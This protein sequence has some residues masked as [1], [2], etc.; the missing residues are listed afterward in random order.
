MRRL[1]PHKPTPMSY[2]HMGALWMDES[3]MHTDAIVVLKSMLCLTVQSLCAA[4]SLLKHW[5]ALS[6]LSLSH[7]LFPIN[8]HSKT[9]CQGFATRQPQVGCQ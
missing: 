2:L 6:N 5:P 7:D 1:P 3:R 8:G 9:P 4:W